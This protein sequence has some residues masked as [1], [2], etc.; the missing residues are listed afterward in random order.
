MRTLALLVLLA[1]AP[2]LAAEQKPRLAVLDL[3]A[4]GAS[5]ELASAAGGVVASELDRL[6]VFK[7]V[8]SDAIRD[9]LAF[10]KQRQMLGCTDGG[11]IAEIGGAL[12]VDYLVSGKV[13]RLAASKDAP[14]S[15]TLELTLSSVKRGQREGSAIETG[16]SEADLLARS[17][18]AVQRLVQKV[19]AG[20]SGTLAVA[21]SEAGAVVKVDDQVKGTTP[22][23][24]QITLPAGPHQL[25]VEKQGFVTFQKDVQVQPGKLT[26]ERA[27]LVP[28]PDFI[29]DYEARQ[30]KVRLGAWISTGVAVAGV[31]GAVLLQA[32]ASRLYGTDSTP[33]TFLHARRKLLDGIEVD[34]VTGVDYRAQAGSLKSQ[35]SQR[36]TLAWVSAGVGGAAAVAATWLW[37]AGDDPARYARYRDVARLEVAPLPGGALASLTLGF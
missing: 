26:D 15:F 12:G 4:N 33:G 14:E 32:D 13:S 17:G 21:S 36:E 27:T 22:L 30:R 11:C 18:K 24:G 10:E 20:R 31:A 19:L 25:V 9:M 16:R 37:I 7:V 35:V 1:A 8:T 5:K 23:Q 28:S 29:R 3:T 2:A 6:A 34:P